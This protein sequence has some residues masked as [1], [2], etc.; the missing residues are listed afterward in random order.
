MKVLQAALDVFVKT[1]EMDYTSAG[2]WVF[3]GITLAVYLASQFFIQALL[4]SSSTGFGKRLFG[5][6]LPLIEAT[7]WFILCSAFIV[8]AIDSEPT[9]TIVLW[10]ST[11]FVFLI[12]GP[13][14][15]SGFYALS[16]GKTFTILLLTL[17]CTGVGAYIAL[18]TG[19]TISGRY[20]AGGESLEAQNKA[21]QEQ[22][23]EHK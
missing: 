15:S 10:S 7:I 14:I 2:F 13:I 22:L 23:N 8:P 21:R 20:K 3:I 1:I 11:A 19:Y 6:I 16:V 17:V 9:G 12:I 18:Q 4:F 5:M